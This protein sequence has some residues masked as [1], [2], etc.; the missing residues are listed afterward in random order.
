ML[1]EGSMKIEVS[2]YARC[3]QKPKAVSARE[4][5]RDE[6]VNVRTV[7]ECWIDI[8][9]MTSG[10][11]SGCLWNLSQ[12][13]KRFYICVFKLHG[14]YRDSLTF[15]IFKMFS[16]F[17]I[18]CI[19]VPSKWTQSQW[20]KQTEKKTFFFFNHNSRIRP[21]AFSDFFVCPI[22]AWSSRASSF[23]W[24]YS[25]TTSSLFLLP[26]FQHVQDS[27]ICIS[28]SRP[29]WRAPIIVFLFFS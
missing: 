10:A 23:F 3:K 1:Q 26:F 14:K 15:M 28:L 16:S 21:M 7:L 13:P 20:G 6:L 5:M 8:Y 4:I 12:T 17:W 11:H 2:T 18:T 27:L 22:L 29:S 19:Y 9:C 25:K 24:A